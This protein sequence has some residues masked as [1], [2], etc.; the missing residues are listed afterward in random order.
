MRLLALTLQDFGSVESASV[1]LR[2][3]ESATISGVNGSGK[4]TVFVDAPLWALFGKCRSDTDSMIRLGAV[5]MS[6]CLWFSLDGHEY[7]VT[8]AR[9]K[10]TKA[11][12]TDLTFEGNGPD[13]WVPIGGGKVNETQEAI[14]SVLNA[15]YDLIT[16]TNYLVQGQADRFTKASPSERKAL[17]AQI[18]QL[19]I[20]DTL[21]G[22][23]SQK[24]NY[25]AGELT[26]LAERLA[27]NEVIAGRMSSW[28]SA[29][30]E[31]K[32]KIERLTGETVAL[33]TQV[34][35]L[36][37]AIGH[38]EG[39]LKE[40]ALRMDV[41][42]STKT[43][44]AE[45]D[46]RLQLIHS[47]QQGHKVIIAKGD[48]IRL[49][50]DA[51]EE[52][53]V[54]LSNAE[55]SLN[56]SQEQYD[57]QVKFTYGLTERDL[58]EKATLE[59]MQ[60]VLA[61]LQFG[62]QRARDTHLGALKE[63][64][65]EI[66]QKGEQVKRL[67]ELPCYEE[68]QE[69]CPYTLEAVEFK[70]AL[71]KLKYEFEKWQGKDPVK[72]WNPDYQKEYDSRQS[73]I[74]NLMHSVTPKDLATAR[75]RSSTLEADLLQRKTDR[76]KYNKKLSEL[77]IVAESLPA[78][79]AAEAALALLKDDDA[80]ERLSARI[81]DGEIKALLV[82]CSGFE[83]VASWIDGAR[84]QVVTL[85]IQAK[86]ADSNLNAAAE[87]LGTYRK[88]WDVTREADILCVKIRQEAKEKELKRDAARKLVELYKAIPIFLMEETVPNL[89]SSCNTILEQISTTGMRI[90]LETQK[91]RKSKEGLVDTL[92]ILVRDRFGE[93]PYENYS[94]GE[95][96][97]IDLAVRLGLADLL[98][99]RAGSR[100]DTL[101][102]DEGLGT[103][104]AE[105]LELL[106]ECLVKLETKFPCILVISHV[107]A[108]LGTFPTSITVTKPNVT[109]QIEVMQ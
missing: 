2:D 60:A 52:M 109:T 92:D 29:M 64:Q 25:L 3:V 71:P 84:V 55:R 65:G 35:S 74:K 72:E 16:A 9:S 44:K 83:E 50:A 14:R 107:E 85:E 28:A 66:I 8:R 32:I 1:N 42:A 81:L 86:T 30:D 11:G 75:A 96:F 10:A 97:R 78:L 47:R 82:Q 88:E 20:Y 91:A 39:S 41:L 95:R 21:R 26:G 87:L 22:A 7:R 102:I 19:D 70:G 56:L 101:V 43:R 17:L 76:A 45:C 98:R 54:Q 38:K 40:H 93:R 80:A 46:F 79:R 100:I 36:R 31:E 68:L 27:E 105:G 106:R 90:T 6:V 94:G 12:K 13:G 33:R 4:S 73:Q 53:K 63:L 37:E 104:D 59:R 5:S 24:N 77:C 23:A 34:N 49:A 51:H 57:I 18:L 15:D 48:E 67:D 99:H 62:A 58:K 69:K 103:L 61:E 108:V 89:E